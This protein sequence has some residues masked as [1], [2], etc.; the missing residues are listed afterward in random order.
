LVPMCYSSLLV[1]DASHLQAHP[2]SAVAP[3]ANGQMIRW[4]NSSLVYEPV[5]I[6][7]TSPVVVTHTAG[8]TSVS[9]PTCSTGSPP[10]IGARVQRTAF[11]SIANNTSS[12]IPFQATRWDT[13]TMWTVG[14][15]SR[16]T[17]HTAGTYDLKYMGVWQISA[18]GTRDFSLLVNGTTTIAYVHLLADNTYEPRVTLSTTWQFA[19]NDFV[20]VIAFQDSGFSQQLGTAGDY[21]AGKAYAT[22]FTMT[23]VAP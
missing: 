8:A 20:E 12:A 10:L 4:N 9:C 15:P 3:S 16:L 1:A 18:T 23:R 2:I 13:D 6:T 7:G 14:S 22:E 11:A 5:A 21:G 17:I 19:V